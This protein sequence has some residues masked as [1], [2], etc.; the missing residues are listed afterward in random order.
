MFGSFVVVVL[1]AQDCKHVRGAM[2]TQ[3]AKK[4]SEFYQ[5]WIWLFHCYCNSRSISLWIPRYLS[6]CLSSYLVPSSVF[7]GL[8]LFQW[9]EISVKT[10]LCFWDFVFCSVF[11]CLSIFV[12]LAMLFSFTFCTLC[13]RVCVSCFLLWSSAGLSLY[14]YLSLSF[15]LFFVVSHFLCF[16]L[17]SLSALCLLLTLFLFVLF[18]VSF[19]LRFDLSAFSIY[20]YISIYKHR[21]KHIYIYIS[22]REYCFVLFLLFFRLLQS[23]LFFLFLF[24]N[25]FCL[26]VVCGSCSCF[27]CACAMYLL[28]SFICFCCGLLLWQFPQTRVYPYPLGAGSARP[29]PKMGAPDPE[30]PLFLGF[31]VLRGELR[32]WSRKG[33][34]HGIG[35]DPETD[36]LCFSL[37]LICWNIAI[38]LALFIAIP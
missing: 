34:D 31:S 3:K 35:V 25:F 1:T 12:R 19:D 20:I 24:V 15:F 9:A 30:N 33:P 8:S 7:L 13:V 23:F 38:K 36:I 10:R 22:Y 14:L 4:S 32:P 18:C 29:N 37:L 17:I 6:V 16:V 11:E 2:C 28:R 26:L 21:N 27:T 5:M